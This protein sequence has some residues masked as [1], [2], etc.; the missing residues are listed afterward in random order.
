MKFSA[1]VS[2]LLPLLVA[3]QKVIDKK[4][5]Q[6]VLQHVLL[7]KVDGCYYLTA[8]TSENELTMPVE[9]AEIDMAGFESCCLD[10]ER[11]VPIF[12]T[13]GN[14]P[15]E[16]DL[17]PDGN[18]MR[19]AYEGGSFSIPYF[20]GD[21]FPIMPD[22]KEPLVEFSLPTATFLQNVL[23]A[24]SFS[25]ADPNTLRPIMASVCLDVSNE[26]V[27]FVGTT[28][29]QLYTNAYYHGVPFLTCGEPRQ[30]MIHQKFVRSLTAPL[31]KT[32]MVTISCDA[33]R[34]KIVADDVK[35]VI[36]SIEGRYPNYRG[37]IPVNH[38]HHAIIDKTALQ[39]A[40]TRISLLSSSH[41]NLI[42]FGR[43][44]KGV[45]LSAEDFDFSTSGREYV[46]VK[47]IESAEDFK[48]GFKG[49]AVQQILG[50]ITSEDVRMEFHTPDRAVLFKET[51]EN[52]TLVE[53]V[54]PMILQD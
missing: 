50:Y 23:A 33:N 14:Q 22:V 45:F 27:T 5:V 42:M 41:S 32:E 21:V 40:L 44:E 2:V 39:K 1:N 16:F 31:K 25:D 30:I 34:L 9:I 13:L 11:I 17:N 26:G 4:A 15:V 8:S 18:T 46:G 43:D 3:M 51:T 29:H 24:Q 48:M 52:S 38:P 6:A 12:N 28:G 54:M 47:E 36:R 20:N 19:V 7:K 53:L 37:V 35:F 10:V 49:S